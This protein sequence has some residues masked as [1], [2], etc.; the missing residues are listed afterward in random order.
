M[1]PLASPA[2]ERRAPLLERAK[3]ASTAVAVDALL[4]LADQHGL[5]DHRDEIVALARHSVRLT[6]PTLLDDP[7]GDWL[8]EPSD[9]LLDDADR[10]VWD[11][12]RLTLVAQLDLTDPVLHDVDL[13]L[14]LTGRLLFLWATAQAPSGQLERHAGAGRVLHI[15]GARGARAGGP[16]SVGSRSH[17]SGRRRSR[18]CAWIRSS[19]TATSGCVAGSRRSRTS[20]STTASACP[21]RITACS[22]IRT[23]PA[24]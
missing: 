17:A 18:S 14:P 19:T 21:S 22:A 9:W 7:V 2:P 12:E 6:T 4:E 23:R 1:R 3:P 8:A 5:S 16:V 13:P 20:S 11:G 15:P 10:P 24:A